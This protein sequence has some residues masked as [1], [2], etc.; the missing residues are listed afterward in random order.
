MFDGLFL[1]TSGLLA[2][3]AW[4]STLSNNLAN[5]D[6]PGFKSETPII[7][8][9]GDVLL[10]NSASGAVIGSLS[11]GAG[12]FATVPDLTQGAIQS[13]GDPLDVALEGPGFMA[14]RTPQGVLY[15][16]DGA[17]G[18]DAAGHLVTDTGALVLDAAGQPITAGPGASIGAD[19]TVSVDGKAVARIGVFAL[20]LGQLTEVGKGLFQAS[21]TPLPDTTTTFVPG[22]LEAS[23]AD[24]V[25]AL[26]QMVAAMRQ[27]EA[28]E[29]LLSQESQTRGSFIQA[30]G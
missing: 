28:A 13:T 6:T 25:T 11:A 3:E 9:F 19:G 7:G 2:D 18:I 14:V 4:Q 24:P 8:S 1:A 10:A 22:S 5:L 26:S 27:F 30:A 21:G 29:H 20:G 12:L 15:T 23:N 16:R 17:L